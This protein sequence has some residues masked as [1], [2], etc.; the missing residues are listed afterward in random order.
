MNNIGIVTDSLEYFDVNTEKYNDSLRKLRYIKFINATSDLDHNIIIMYDEDK[1]EILKSRYEIVGIYSSD[2]KTWAW[3]W[4]VPNF[5]KNSTNIVRKI[6]NYGAELDPSNKFL[7]TELITSRFR[8]SDPIQLDIH[9]AI[10]SYLSKKP[11]IY[12]YYIHGNLSEKADNEGYIDIKGK[13][14]HYVINFI[15]LLDYDKLKI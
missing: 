13:S 8:I 14:D 6:M 5:K 15:F 2:T 4:A 3:G 7:K 11:L 9:V 10:A 12:K 1:N